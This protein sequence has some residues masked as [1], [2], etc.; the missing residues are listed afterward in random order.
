[1][2]PTF[3]LVLTKKRI[4]PLGSCTL[5]HTLWVNKNR[6][7]ISTAQTTDLLLWISWSL[8]LEYAFISENPKTSVHWRISST[9][10][11]E[12]FQK[13]C[14]SQIRLSRWSRILSSPSN[15]QFS[16]LKTRFHIQTRPFQYSRIHNAASSTVMMKTQSTSS[17]TSKTSSSDALIA[18]ILSSCFLTI[19]Y[20]DMF[21]MTAGVVDTELWRAL[22]IDLY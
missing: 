22:G 21:S 1:M 15:H 8:Q 4:N 10:W 16:R 12:N 14:R 3:S 20:A 18:S 11:R 19:V 17:K 7:Q 6:R 5:T 9:M 2:K 13:A